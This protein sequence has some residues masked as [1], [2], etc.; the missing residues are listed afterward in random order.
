M[1]NYDFTEGR[2]D[3]L[4]LLSKSGLCK[5][6]SE[7]R[8]AVEQGGVEAAG[9]KVTEI[10]AN[11]GKDDISGDGLIIRKGKKNYCRKKKK[12]I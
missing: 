7:A 1:E 4:S 3:I 11:Y 9:V 6:K 2:I 5:S 8:R 12:K 10:S